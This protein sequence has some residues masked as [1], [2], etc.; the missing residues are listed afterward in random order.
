MKKVLRADIDQHFY[1]QIKKKTNPKNQL[2]R[3]FDIHLSLC[4]TAAVISVILMRDAHVN[5]G[6]YCEIHFLR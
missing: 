6:S 3:K 4:L 2:F 1:K 5:S